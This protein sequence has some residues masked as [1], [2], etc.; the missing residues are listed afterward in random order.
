MSLYALLIIGT[1]IGPFALSFDKKI[2]FYTYFKV[3]IPSI[4]IVA[5]TFIVWDEFFTQKAIWGFNPDYLSG[6]YLGSLPIEEVSFFIVVPFACMF[7]YEVLKGY[8]PN[9]K[10]E[11]MG[12]IVAFTI[13]LAGLIFSI[14]NLENWYTLSACVLAVLLS[15]RFFFINRSPWYEDFAFAYLVAIIPFTL[16]NG[17]L[18]G[19]ATPEPV[20]WYSEAHIMGV[21]FISIPLEDFFYNYDMLILVCFLFEKFKLQ[22]V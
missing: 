13:T 4:I 21:R 17:V 5:F 1:F 7:I 3:L 12:K 8:F 18:T 6:I 16:V 14:S 10:K 19:M 20:V 11:K 15:I 22:K 9:L 2:H